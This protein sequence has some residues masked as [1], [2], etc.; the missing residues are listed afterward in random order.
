MIIAWVLSLLLLMASLI[1]HLQRTTTLE[2]IAIQTMQASQANFIRA[3][4]ALLEC[5]SAITHFASLPA[6][7]CKV[8]S[9]GKQLWKVS[10]AGE[11]TLESI[12]FLGDVSTTPVRLSWR[13]VFWE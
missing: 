10:T 1:A 9:L 5:E 13:Q 8:Q 2:I 11:P 6:N 4:K 12:V 7:Q 3:E